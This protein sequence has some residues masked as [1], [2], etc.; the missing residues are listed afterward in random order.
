MAALPLT[1]Q[2]L[3][4]L[5]TVRFYSSISIREVNRRTIR[6]NAV[7]LETDLVESLL[8]KFV[9]QFPAFLFNEKSF[10][11]KIFVIDYSHVRPIIGGVIFYFCKR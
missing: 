7:T 11:S 1:A 5:E 10:Q 4:S 9:Y 8:S 6:E 2:V 3:Q